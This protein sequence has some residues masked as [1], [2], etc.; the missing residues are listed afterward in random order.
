MAFVVAPCGGGARV[1]GHTIRSSTADDAAMRALRA[2][3]FEKTRSKPCWWLSPESGAS[4]GCRRSRSRSRDRSS[5]HKESRKPRQTSEEREAERQLQKE[6]REAE[7]RQRELEELDRDTRT[8]F[9]Y[10]LA[11]K[12]GERDIF[13]FFSQAGGVRPRHGERLREHGT[14]HL[15]RLTRDS[16]HIE[17]VGADGVS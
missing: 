16:V 6:K 15:L 4:C 14:E 12:A 1:V 2:S 8:V 13:E 7:E 5:R 11:T 9:A 17:R 10:N 3:R